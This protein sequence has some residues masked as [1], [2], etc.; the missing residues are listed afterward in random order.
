MHRHR[1]PYEEAG[2]LNHA[3]N[4]FANIMFIK[5]A[6][7]Q[8]MMYC[9]CLCVSVSGCSTK[10]NDCLLASEAKN[11]SSQECEHVAFESK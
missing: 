4:I 9:M 2:P 3:S 11:K 5:Q 8:G 6:W 1:K 7:S 10:E